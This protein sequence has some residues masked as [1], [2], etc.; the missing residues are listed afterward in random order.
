[1][2]TILRVGGYI[3][4]L[5]QSRALEVDS[6]SFSR[7]AVSNGVD[8]HTIHETQTNENQF[9]LKPPRTPASLGSRRSTI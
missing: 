1:M 3:L 4:L 8:D 2:G 6:T 5:E 9:E 7:E